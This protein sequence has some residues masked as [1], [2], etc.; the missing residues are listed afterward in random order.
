MR[1]RMLWAAAA[2]S[3]VLSM[4]PMRGGALISLAGP[5][6]GTAAGT[7]APPVAA[8]LRVATFNVL[9]GLEETPS[10]PTHSTFDARLEL[11]A[12]EIVAEGLDVVGMQEVSET[13]A[14]VGHAPGN[15]AERLAG[16]LAEITDQAWHWCWHLSNP[17]LPVEPDIAEGGGGPVSDVIASMASGNYGSFKEGAAVLSRY[18]IVAAETRRLPLR[19]PLEYATCPPA[20]IPDCNLTAIFDHR[21]ALW[22]RVGTPGG[23]TDIIATHFAHH[24][25]PFSETSKFTHAA[26]VLAFSEQMTLQHGEPAR[27]FITCDCNLETTD[28]PPGVELIISAGWTDSYAFVHPDSACLPGQDVSGCTSDQDIVTETP[29]ATTNSRI[30]YVFAR[31]G[32]CPLEI[33]DSERI[34]DTPLLRPD[35]TYLWPSD[36]LAVATDITIAGCASG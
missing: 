2:A 17:H 9:H 20:E 28:Q 24:L 1:T 8:T 5:K 16:R 7:E 36:H 30:D 31:G 34:A 10:Y 33:A 25:T 22:A 11:Q 21:I 3:V 35:G 12:Q 4:V 19:V 18:P 14:P 15:V 27:R 29:A 13:E 23:A 6:C 32:S 26:A